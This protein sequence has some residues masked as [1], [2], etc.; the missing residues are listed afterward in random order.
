[1]R[2]EV[3]PTAPTPGN[4]WFGA[5]GAGLGGAA[6]SPKFVMLGVHEGDPVSGRSGG[7]RPR[8]RDSRGGCGPIF[9]FR[10]RFS[11]I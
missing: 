2:F 10:P 3:V 11:A 5:L 9:G 7:L 6:E 1:M 8:F 4:M